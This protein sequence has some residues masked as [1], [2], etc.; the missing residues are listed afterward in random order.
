MLNRGAQLDSWFEKELVCPRDKSDLR[1]DDAHL[2]CAQHH[3]YPIA[4]GIPIMLVPEVSQTA[5]AV[6]SRSLATIEERIVCDSNTATNGAVDPYVQN[7]I[8]GTNGNLYAPLRGKLR[9]YPI[10]VIRLA[11]AREGFRDL[12]D[13]G[14][15][16]GRWCIAAANRGY[17]PVGMDPGLESIIPARRIAKQLGIEARFLVGDAR[18]I[19]FRESR[20]EVVHSYGVLQHFSHPDAKLAMTEAARVA[21]PNGTVMIQMAARY[22]LLSILQQARRGFRDPSGFEVRYWKPSEIESTLRSLV[23]PTKLSVDG[24]LT[25]NPQVS[26]LDLLPIHY[27]QIVRLSELLC[28]LSRRVP[29]MLK[30]ADSIFATSIKSRHG[31]ETSLRN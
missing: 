24:Y 23:G 1:H 4:D 14:C 18:F 10:P 25:L 31:E 30:I 22:G 11:P 19:P 21:S 28:G 20:F 13:L 5:P 15:N 7:A 6:T 17:R 2:V 27:R 8:V 16:W 29:P 26:D 3:S 12:L 9:R